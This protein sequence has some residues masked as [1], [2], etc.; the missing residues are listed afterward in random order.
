MWKAPGPAPGSKQLEAAVNVLDG[1]GGK[2]L[3]PPD[4]IV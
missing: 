3:P 1:M 2:P 4:V